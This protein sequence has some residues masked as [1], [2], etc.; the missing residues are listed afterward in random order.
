MIKE[1]VQWFL[2]VHHLTSKVHSQLIFL[3]I[4][5]IIRI[6]KRTR[7]INDLCINFNIIFRNIE[8][9]SHNGAIACSGIIINTN[10]FESFRQIQPDKFIDSIGRH[11]LNAIIDGTALKEPWRLTLF[12]IFSYADLKKY[13]FH[14][15]AAFPTAFN[16]PEM[17]HQS[18]PQ[19]IAD[20]FP[21]HCRQKLKENFNNLDSRSKCFFTTLITD[22]NDL[23]IV[24]LAEGLESVK[25]G[26]KQVHTLFIDK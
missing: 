23:E 11:F 15:W 2:I 26:E 12:L 4:K 25:S 1:Q 8:T 18:A 7:D 13:R 20:V 14:Y 3:H 10:T 21:I 17:Y 24:S 22:S 5:I 6:Y 16:L 19:Q 9:T